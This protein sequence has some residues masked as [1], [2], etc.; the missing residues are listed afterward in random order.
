MDF[1]GPDF[2]FEKLVGR[3]TYSDRAQCK[4]GS[5][6]AMMRQAKLQVAYSCKN[7]KVFVYAS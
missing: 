3:G 1:L 7:G 5:Q 6:Y 4:C 2:F